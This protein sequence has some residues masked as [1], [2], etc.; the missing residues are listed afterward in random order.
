MKTSLTIFFTVLC[1]HLSTAQLQNLDFE[2]WNIDQ[3][4]GNPIKPT[5]WFDNESPICYQDSSAFQG[6]FALGVSVWYWYSKTTAFQTAPISSRPLALSGFYKY[7][8]NFVRFLETD[9]IVDDTALVEVYLTKWNNATT[10]RDT[11][12]TGK[13]PLFERLEYTEFNCFINYNSNDLPDT[14]NVI[15]DPSIMRR[16]LMN[17]GF[18]ATTESGRCSFLTIDKLS[19]S[20]DLTGLPNISKNGELLVFPNPAQNY[21]QL[22]VS[23]DQQLS[24]EIIDSFGK[25]V[26]RGEFGRDSQPIQVS[27]FCPG[28]YLVRA[29][30]QQ[31][32]I[33]IKR[34]VKV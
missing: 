28:I 6:D 34:F 16:Y 31:G 24:F 3:T 17:S 14:I 8:D 29:I 32:N 13:L 22:D 12:G 4:S 30:D 18:F 33:R 15:F 19:L 1:F 25:S 11:L 9:E 27:T 20:D 10:R 5:G 21:I 2:Q 23:G 7:T 26:Q